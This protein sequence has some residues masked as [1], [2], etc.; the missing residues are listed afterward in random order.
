MTITTFRHMRLQ[1]TIQFAHNKSCGFWF[2]EHDGRASSYTEY[3]ETC[4]DR[5]P[6]LQSVINIQ[7][8]SNHISA[9]GLQ[10]GP[11]NVEIQGPNIRISHADHPKLSIIL[12]GDGFSF[13]PAVRDVY[14]MLG[15]TCAMG[16]QVQHA[17]PSISI[18]C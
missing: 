15:I 12:D 9:E 2:S 8:S 18:E 5:F 6:S 3:G 13:S 10:C 16:L 1:T 17:R 4:F 14:R 7:N 11:W